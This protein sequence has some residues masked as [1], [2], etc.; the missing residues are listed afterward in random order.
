MPAD[1]LIQR[2]H[3]LAALDLPIV[4]QNKVIPP[5]SIT[6]EDLC[7]L[8]EQA[9]WSVSLDP[10]NPSRINIHADGGISVWLGFDGPYLRF[11]SCWRLRPGVPVGAALV[12]INQANCAGFGVTFC[13]YPALPLQPNY[14]PDYPLPKDIPAQSV[15]SCFVV[16]CAH[17]VTLRQLEGARDN[18]L[19][20]NNLA[21]T[22]V[23]K[24][25]LL[26]EEPLETAG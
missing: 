4:M 13:Y 9:D 14:F 22:R 26:G 16:H 21:M 20:Q 2:V 11:T 12:L 3:S 8:L 17:G 19:L 7:P 23:F 6:P 5:E 24:L 1:D 18:F 25:G 15:G 10:T